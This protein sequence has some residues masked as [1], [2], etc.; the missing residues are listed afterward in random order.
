MVPPESI[1]ALVVAG[2]LTKHF[3]PQNFLFAEVPHG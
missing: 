1:T 2:D 3:M